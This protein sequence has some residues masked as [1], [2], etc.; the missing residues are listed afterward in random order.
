MKA[1]KWNREKN[2]ELIKERNISFEINDEIFLKTKF[3][4]RKASK[5]YF[6]ERL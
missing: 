6:E 1:I 3:P 5:L 4:S 2:I